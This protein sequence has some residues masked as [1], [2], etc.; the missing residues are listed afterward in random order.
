[1]LNNTHH[2]DIFCWWKRMRQLPINLDGRST[3][4]IALWPHGATLTICIVAKIPAAIRWGG[5]S[6]NRLDYHHCGQVCWPRHR[7]WPAAYCG[8]S[9]LAFV[10]DSWNQFPFSSIK[11]LRFF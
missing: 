8:T 11:E 4:L 7:G 5:R 10:C 9:P 2:L 1:L 3:V 6:S